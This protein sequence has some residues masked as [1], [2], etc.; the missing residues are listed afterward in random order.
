MKAKPHNKVIDSAYAAALGINLRHLRAVTAVAAAGS[1]SGAAEGLYRVPS[2]VTRS[3]SELEGALGR[4]LFDRRSRGMALNAYGELVLARARRVEHEF[5]Q[6]QAQLVARGG[7]RA[8]ADVNSLFASILNGRRLAVVASLAEKRNMPSV[9]HEFGITQPGISAAVKDLEEGLGVALFDRTA[10]GLAPTPAG[11]IV[12]FY[13]KRV[14]A[15]LRHIGPDIAASEGTVQGSV[16]VGA[17]PL[18]RTQILPLA[19]ASLLARHPLVHVATVES[20]YDA[21]AASLRSG[22]VDFIFGAL[23]SAAETKDL[24]QEALFEDRISVIARAGHPLA[25]ARRIDFDTLRKA[26]WVLSRHGAPSRELLERFFS[27]AQQ[28]P[29]VP[30]VETGD[31]ALLRGLLMESD[32]LTAISAHQLRYEIRDGSL[33]VLDFPLDATRRDIGLTQRLGAFPSPGAR[34]LMEEIRTVLAQ[35]PD[36]RGGA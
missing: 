3:I 35:S 36:F 4:P 27:D 15:E 30:A 17:L 19:I 33:V 24:Q 32:M 12:A 28:A 29:P 20:P 10:R 31:L 11:D 6:A 1:I 7:M 9:A 23:R 18:G 13:F 22:D 14:L 2:A 21:L 16:H 25:H 8:S 34:A 5:A 26:R